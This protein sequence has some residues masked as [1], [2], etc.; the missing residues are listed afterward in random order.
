M[1][2]NHRSQLRVRVT[3]FYRLICSNRRFHPYCSSDLKL[4]WH[5][6]MDDIVL[7]QRKISW[8]QLTYGGS[9]ISSQIV[10]CSDWS[11]HPYWHFRTDLSD[12]ARLYIR[13]EYSNSRYF[14]DGDIFCQL[15]HNQIT[16]NDFEEGRWL[17]RLS[18]SK[19][20]DLNQ[21]QK[22]LELK[23]LNLILDKLLPFRGL[24]P[25]LQIGTFHRLLTLKCPEVSW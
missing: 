10:G 20:K 5:V 17:A 15:R 9:W 1:R 8:A 4:R 22:R 23:R 25:P 2:I 7:L 16:L 19:R 13:E 18:E 11:S 14:C 12:I 24:W 21:L 3:M 6:Y